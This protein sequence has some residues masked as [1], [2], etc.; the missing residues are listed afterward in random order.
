MKFQISNFKFR[1]GKALKCRGDKS[2][3]LP[4]DSQFAIRNSQFVRAFTLIE[5]LLVLA[6]IGLLAALGMP[7]LKGFGKSN[8]VA[9]AHRQMLD[10]IAAARQLAIADHTSVYMVFAPTNLNLAAFAGAP[11]NFQNGSIQ[12]K[13]VTNLAQSKYTSYSLL[14]LRQVGDQPGQNN[15]RYL[16]PWKS[17][18]NGMMFA[19]RK[20]TIGMSNY[21]VIDK[22]NATEKIYGFYENSTFPFPFATNPPNY[23]LPYIAFNYL[24]QLTKDGINLADADQYIPLSSGSVFYDANFN[25]DPLEKPIG[26]YITNYNLVHIDR[27]TGRARIERAEIIR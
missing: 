22:F 1:I 9:A 21:F 17:L 11:Y 18:P 25:A 27:L 16:S 24:G 23:R 12:M 7:A 5:L 8:S 15:P 6:I 4:A 26:N 14:T 20:Y 3:R 13:V 19:P 10:D 2:A